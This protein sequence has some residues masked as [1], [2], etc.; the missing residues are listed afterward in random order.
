MIARRHNGFTLVEALVALLVFGLV[1][2]LVLAVIDLETRIDRTG[3]ARDA[4]TGQVV[5]AQTLLRHRI[6]EIHALPD[7][8]GTGD[9]LVFY[10]SGTQVT[11]VAPAFAAHGPHALQ[12]FRLAISPKR[13][14]TLYTASTL[15]GID[16]RAPL[17]DGWQALALVDRVDWMQIDYFG[18][19]RLSGRDAWQIGWGGRPDLPKLVRI[20]LG[21]VAGDG[22]RWPVLMVR[23][24]SAQS[25]PC[26]EGKNCGAES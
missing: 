22:R 17:N 11:F 21:F 12:Q 26:P 8:Q 1:S 3:A 7:I 16:A 13:A 15:A 20:R 10:G 6:E 24:L 9:R 4:D 25:I 18:R 5:T 14:L 19:D 23:P 2:S